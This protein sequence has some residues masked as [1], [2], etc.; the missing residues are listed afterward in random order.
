MNNTFA[1]ATFCYGER[2]QNQVN[3]LITE[4]NNCV[5][6]PIVVVVTDDPSKIKN[7]SFV[8]IFDILEFNPEYKNYADSYYEFDFSVKRYSLLAALNLGFTKIILTD[9]DAV[10][11]K[12][13]FNEETILKGFVENSIQ[14]QVTYNFSNEISTN[15]QLG[16]RF[17]EY[18]KYF[19]RT[20]DK[21][22]LDFMPEDCVQFID[23]DVSKFYNFLSI[24]DK[25]IELKKREKL[26]NVP[27]GN[28]DEMCFSALYCGLTVGN[29]SNKIVNA[30]I[31]LHDK[32]YAGD[33]SPVQV[34]ERKKIIV[35][36]IY[37]L[38]YCNE[39][40]SGLYKGIDLLTIT[41]RN[42]I[43]DGFEYV[44]YTDK[45]TYEK[46]HLS[47]LI[48]QKNVTFKFVELN[49]DY[50]TS[51]LKPIQQRRLSE[52]EIWDRIH[53]VNNYIEVILNKLEFMIKESN[54]NP[55]AD[56]VWLDSGLFGT[57][58]GNGWRDYIKELAHSEIFLKNIFNKI[59]EYNF[60]CTK[61]E[62]IIINYEIKGKLNQEFQTNVSII[63][64]C[65]FGGSSEF[66]L[67]YLDSYKDMMVKIV[68]V[69]ND[70]T[71]EQEM[72]FLLL[73]DKN[74]KFYEFLDWD[75]LQR[76]FL[77]IMDIY[78]ENKYD[79][80]S[81]L[82]YKSPNLLDDTK[83][84]EVLNDLNFTQIADLFGIDKGSLHEGH[85]YTLTYEEHLTKYKSSKPCI[86]EIGINDTRFPGGCLKF[87]DSIFENMEYYGFDIVDCTHLKYNVDK[88]KIFK[89][90][91]NNKNNL[92]EFIYK[93]E[94]PNRID[95]IIDDGSH[96]S[97]HILTSF[98]TLYPFLKNGGIYFIEDLH[99]GWAERDK[100]LIEI[101][102]IIKYKNFQVSNK[103]LTNNQKLLMITK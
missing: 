92:L 34:N 103:T 50:Y 32:W 54:L 40:G 55:D 64:G 31:N 38:F 35:S 36:S 67:D 97:E 58:C 39:R 17:L 84:K 57:S 90:D 2:Y 18:E 75:D 99:A 73:R 91:Q 5:F 100:T 49:S 12:S 27:A 95:V 65:L 45:N 8:K 79:I 43:F 26:P 11:N 69:L 37:E 20:F 14:G 15:S 70:Y 22:E 82:S 24:W 53:C 47:Q 87:W 63:P 80:S 83:R 23:I 93:Y 88:I 3:R 98:E 52:G 66:I 77:K 21:S 29:N 10:P 76:A 59:S 94:L 13:L 61:G 48:P 6:K 30:L 56:L 9:A 25:C 102:K 101:D 86:V 81:C 46:Y 19:E 44:I 7:F 60:I 78:D 28:I 16:R 33:Q 68:N 62:N 1:I 42:S 4:I 51:Y 96:H 72:L 41:I 85:M 74:V 89:G 71:S